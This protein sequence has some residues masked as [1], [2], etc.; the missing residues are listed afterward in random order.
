MI[1][2]IE[3]TKT[4]IKNNQTIVKNRD[5]MVFHDKMGGYWKQTVKQKNK[6][7]SKEVVIFD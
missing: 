7:S 2:F 3:Y 1:N 6:K 5:L 4:T